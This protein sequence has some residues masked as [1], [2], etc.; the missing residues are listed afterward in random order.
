MKDAFEAHPEWPLAYED[1]VLHKENWSSK[2]INV[3]QVAAE[4]GIS[5]FQAFAFI[6]DNP[7]EV[8]DV[9][10]ACP[11]VSTF[12]YPKGE[13]SSYVDH[14]W[15]LDTFL[16]TKEDTSKTAMMRVRH[17]LLLRSLDPRIASLP[18]LPLHFPCA[19]AP[20]DSHKTLS[21]CFDRRR[22]AGKGLPSP[23]PA[24]P[25]SLRPLT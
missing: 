19:F 4:L 8:A 2:G 17:Q 13:A 3:S 7:V 22:W 18:F 23:R 1:F 21:V 25:T 11:G 6:D 5:E 24:L 20:T 14:C 12:L 16:V 15:P 10:A 9:Q